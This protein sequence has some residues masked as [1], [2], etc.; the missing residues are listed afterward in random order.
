MFERYTLGGA[1]MKYMM[2]RNQNYPVNN[3]FESMFNDWL[4]NWG[5]GSSNVP[6][7]DVEENDNN[8]VVSAELPGYKEDEVQVN[9]EKH[10]LHIASQKKE[11]HDE[12]NGKK[13]LIKER[14]YQSFERSFSLPEDADENNIQ[15]SFKDGVLNVNIPKKAVA[16]PKRIQIQIG[17]KN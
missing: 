2:N 6:A 17:Q 1:T 9:V 10:V 7:V 3:D 15:A 12:H 13:Y 14:C 4:G 8:Y 11:N 5:Y 16:Q